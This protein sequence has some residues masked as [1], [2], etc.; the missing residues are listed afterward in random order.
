[1]DLSDR[2]ISGVILQYPDTDGTV[3]DFSCMVEDAHN[4][5]V[6]SNHGLCIGQGY[7]A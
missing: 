5:G 4:S 7:S 1:M 2:D 3:Y 6:S